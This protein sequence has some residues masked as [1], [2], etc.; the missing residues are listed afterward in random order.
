[1]LVVDSMTLPKIVALLFTH[2]IA[3]FGVV[4]K[5]LIPIIFLVGDDISRS[6]VGASIG[7]Q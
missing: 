6:V 7:A 2:D 4:A 1:M 5:R 3:Y